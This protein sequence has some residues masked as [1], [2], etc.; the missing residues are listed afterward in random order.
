MEKLFEKEVIEGA[1]HYL[2]K[3]RK[4]GAIDTDRTFY[5]VVWSKNGKVCFDE[6]PYSDKVANDNEAI[7]LFKELYNWQAPV[8]LAVILFDTA[9]KQWIAKPPV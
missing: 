3:E 9:H 2:E 7:S 1:C 6:L 8:Y 5:I 4:K